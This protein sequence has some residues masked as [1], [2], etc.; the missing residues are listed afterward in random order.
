[1]QNR[2]FM[3][4]FCR[5]AASERGWQWWLWVRMGKEERWG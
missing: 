5:K 3:A 2:D 1:M 4:V